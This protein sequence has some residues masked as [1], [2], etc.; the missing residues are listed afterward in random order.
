MNC[1]TPFPTPKV[2]GLIP[3]TPAQFSNGRWRVKPPTSGPRRFKLFC[4]PYAGGGASIFR[5]W[6]ADTVPSIRILPV[7]LRGRESRIFEP[8]LESVPELAEAIASEIAPA[9][10]SPFVFFGYSFGALLAFE[11]TRLLRRQGIGPDRLIV[12]SLKAPH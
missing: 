9:I 12:A 4:F 10:E 7:R 11:T 3:G 6:Q 5:S 1:R 8:P 2:P